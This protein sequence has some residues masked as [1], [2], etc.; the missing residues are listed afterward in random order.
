MTGALA[1][2][3]LLQDAREAGLQV[4]VV[5]VRPRWRGLVDNVLAREED[6]LGAPSAGG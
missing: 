1:L 6:P 4:E 3:G 2:R 5:D